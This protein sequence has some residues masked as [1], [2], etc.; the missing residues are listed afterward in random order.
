VL[1]ILEPFLY[2]ARRHKTLLLTAGSVISSF[3]LYQE[4]LMAHYFGRLVC[5]PVGVSV[6]GLVV[7]L[8][9]MGLLSVALLLGFNG[10]VWG[11]VTSTTAGRFSG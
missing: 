7:R 9:R 6:F 1:T 5:F 2:A 11:T 3:A 8:L 4:F 10:I